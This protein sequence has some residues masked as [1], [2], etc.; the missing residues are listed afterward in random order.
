LTGDRKMPT[1]EPAG[2][3]ELNVEVIVAKNQL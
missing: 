3:L 1:P 2:N